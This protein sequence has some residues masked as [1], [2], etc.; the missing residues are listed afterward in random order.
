MCVFY[1]LSL[2]IYKKRPTQH[3]WQSRLSC[4]SYFPGHL[5]LVVQHFYRVIENYIYYNQ[6]TTAAASAAVAAKNSPHLQYTHTQNPQIQN[7]KKVFPGTKAEKTEIWTQPQILWPSRAFFIYYF[8]SLVCG[9]CSI[10]VCFLHE[11]LSSLREKFC[12]Q[13]IYMTQFCDF[14]LVFFV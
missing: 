12:K 1:W 3:L 10:Y 7:N 11:I 8:Y 4:L 13:K 14:F 9:T 6:P 5:N 2:F